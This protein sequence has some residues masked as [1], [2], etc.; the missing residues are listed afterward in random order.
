MAGGRSFPT[1][2]TEGLGS[3]VRTDHRITAEG[4]NDFGVL[5]SQQDKKQDAEFAPL[6][7]ELSKI[8]ALAPSIGNLDKF[9]WN[10]N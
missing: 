1:K 7:I 6:V 9:R 8:R 10:K 3:S 5:Q 2:L 4:D